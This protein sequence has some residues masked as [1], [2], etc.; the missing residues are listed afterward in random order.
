MTKKQK[1]RHLIVVVIAIV[2][3]KLNAYGP[4]NNT[5]CVMQKQCY[6]KCHIIVIYKS[7]NETN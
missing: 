1:L 6:S 3:S 5:W 7:L 4:E 2:Y